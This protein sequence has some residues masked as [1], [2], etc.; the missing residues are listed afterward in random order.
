MPRVFETVDSRQ[1]EYLRQRKPALGT[2]VQ[3]I[4]GSFSSITDCYQRVLASREL[5]AWWCM[6]ILAGRGGLADVSYR[7]DAHSRRGEVTYV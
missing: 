1:S 3:L 4:N 5:L 7:Y 6:A 2:Q